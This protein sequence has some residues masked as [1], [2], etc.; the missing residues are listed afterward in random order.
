MRAG[1]P[2][3]E[4]EFSKSR[5][6]KR[7]L[8]AG[9]AAALL[10]AMVGTPVQAARKQTSTSAK[11]QDAA[12]SEAL[13][14]FQ[15]DLA[16]L[17]ALRAEPMPLLGA[18]LLARPL[19]NPPKG[20]RFGHLIERAEKAPGAGPAATWLALTDCDAKADACPNAQALTQ[21]TTQ[22]AD[23]AAVWLLKLGQDVRNSDNDAAKAD[24]ARA[25]SA[26]LYDDYA[27]TSLKAL[28]NAVGTL[29][30][31]SSLVSSTSASGPYG[32]QVILVF[33]LGGTQPQPV[34]AATATLCKNGE[35]ATKAQCLKLAKVLEW[36]SSPLARSLGLHLR[37]TL[38]ADDADRSAAK[39]ER[40]NLTWQVQNYGQLAGRAA[41]DRT[42]A[43]HLLAL[44]GKGGTEMSLMLAAL[45]GEN[46]PVTA[47]ADWQPG[48]ADSAP[49][50]TTALR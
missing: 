41:S 33:G 16:S 18:A 50:Q 19:S 11:A 26:A 24:L 42:V 22:A 31:P 15:R 34:L 12:R 35:E 4:S 36:G 3:S 32:V 29:P 46:I 9:L 23:N 5:S 49:E 14:G 1:F 43:Q 38:S 27:G 2:R 39:T 6:F 37:E 47:P 21:L 8:A 40:R 44:A 13:L 17:L 25:A 30:P 7:P 10:L 20:L 48:A 28:A 45:R